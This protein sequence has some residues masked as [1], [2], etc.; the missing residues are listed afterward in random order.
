M[1]LLKAA[2]F[3]SNGVSVFDALRAAYCDGRIMSPD[4]YMVSWVYRG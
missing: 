2:V 1:R 4:S 3:I